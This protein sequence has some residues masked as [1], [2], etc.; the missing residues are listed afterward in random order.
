MTSQ[1]RPLSDLVGSLI[2]PIV[3]AAHFFAMYGAEALICTEGVGFQ[4]MRLFAAAAT[5]I[6][7]GIL[8]VAIVRNRQ[9]MLPSDGRVPALR[10]ISNTLS[11]ISIGA[12]LAVA[13]PAAIIPTCVTLVR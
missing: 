2:G 11:L 4:N 1:P 3:W 8:A 5:A 6:A 9:R 12:V 13:L 7:V 10:E